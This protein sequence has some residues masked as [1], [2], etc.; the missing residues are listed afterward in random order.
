MQSD[1]T[2]ELSDLLSVKQIE[3]D[4]L[5]SSFK[6]RFSCLNTVDVLA[7]EAVARKLVTE[8]FFDNGSGFYPSYLS[9]GR[10]LY[11]PLGDVAGLYKDD[12]EDL[13]EHLEQ[14]ALGLKWELCSLWLG[15][16]RARR[17]LLSRHFDNTNDERLELKPALIKYRSHH[18]TE[19]VKLKQNGIGKLTHTLFGMSG[20]RR[21]MISKHEN[22]IEQA[23]GWLK[24][25]SSD[26]RF[27]EFK[28]FLL[29]LEDASVSLERAQEIAELSKSLRKAVKADK[30]QVL[31]SKAAR[32]DGQIRSEAQ[33][34]RRKIKP[35]Q[36]CPYCGEDLDTDMQLD[37]IYPVSRGGLNLENNLVFCCKSC[38]Q[39]KSDLGLIE[40]VMQE[41]LDL[42]K[43][44]ARLLAL[45][46]QI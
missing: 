45:G 17:Q 4:S 12:P 11:V 39:K 32:L 14:E 24:L 26:K 7:V 40:F 5:W 30:R 19:L 22:A 44:T 42:K 36:D 15:N 28:A 9:D 41:G 18:Q 20:D 23:D 38:N 25:V 10:D 6:A 2:K 21:Q 3:R 16:R 31:K 35:S 33:V 29:A 8:V 34:V 1:Q 46:K 27:G 43:V 37:H 13:L